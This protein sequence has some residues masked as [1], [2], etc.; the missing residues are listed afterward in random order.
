MYNTQ[1]ATI[2][3]DHFA[4][5]LRD[6]L[7]LANAAT[8]LPPVTLVMPKS[9]EVSS[10]V[11]GRTGVAGR[12]TLPSVSIDSSGKQALGT[13]DHDLIEYVYAGQIMGLVS[14]SNAQEVEQ[15]C[16]CYSAATELFIIEHLNAPFADSFDESNLPF[17]ITEFG[18]AG[19]AR[20]GAANVADDQKGAPASSRYWVDGFRTE[21]YWKVSEMGYGQHG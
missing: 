16:K 19:S 17:R 8:G 12:E 10:I 11:G 18:F 2:T 14:G 1:I 21:V 15:I 20:F 13:T 7:D 4:E 6:L 9:L 3:R 5:H